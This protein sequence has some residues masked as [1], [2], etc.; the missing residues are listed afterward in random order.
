MFLKASPGLRPAVPSQK[1]T[2]DIVFAPHR[3]R[4]LGR[5]IVVVCG[6]EEEGVGAK[7]DFFRG[8]GGDLNLKM[9]PTQGRRRTKMTHF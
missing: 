4:H 1:N 3:S 7:I 8:R 2:D 6:G 5:S 9:S